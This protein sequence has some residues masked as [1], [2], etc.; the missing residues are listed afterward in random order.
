MPE[1]MA[2]ALGLPITSEWRRIVPGGQ[3]G[4]R[5]FSRSALVGKASGRQAETA[6]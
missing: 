1:M 3:I 6:R 4:A 2:L 5:L